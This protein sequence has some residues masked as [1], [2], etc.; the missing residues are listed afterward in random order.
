VDRFDLFA[1]DHLADALY[2]FLALISS[3][4]S[5]SSYDEILERVEGPDL[6]ARNAIALHGGLQNG[7]TVAIPDLLFHPR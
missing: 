4:I 1:C 6:A 2:W 7:L 5:L 3:P